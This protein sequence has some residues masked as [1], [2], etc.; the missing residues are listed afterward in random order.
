MSSYC[1]RGQRKKEA[2]KNAA[3]RA[4]ETACGLV[5]GFRR[6]ELVTDSPDRQQKTGFEWV[7]FDL[8]PQSV[9]EIIYGAGGTVVIVAPDSLQNIFARQDLAGIA[10]HE[11][12]QFEFLR[13]QVDLLPMEPHGTARQ[14]DFEGA[15]PD[16]L[17]RT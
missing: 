11:A 4:I 6:R 16:L 8:L 17:S 7:F 2:G 3:T 10:D 13:G 14:V 5:S 15:D 1:H 9:D 12:E